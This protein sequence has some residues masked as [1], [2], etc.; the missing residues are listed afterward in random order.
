MRSTTAPAWQVL[1]L[2]LKVDWPVSLVVSRRQMLQYQVRAAAVQ[3][4]A[5]CP[6]RCRAPPLMCLAHVVPRICRVACGAVSRERG[7]AASC[8]R[9]FLA[10]TRRCLGTCRGPQVIFKHLFQLKFAERQLNT[11]WAAL[12]PTRGLAR[13]GG[14]VW[15][16]ERCRAPPGV[17]PRRIAA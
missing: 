11:V 8:G 16:S 7:A 17:P 9:C 10:P 1:L 14:V 3:P 5:V 12:Q 6:P 13:C 4:P 2:D 15:G